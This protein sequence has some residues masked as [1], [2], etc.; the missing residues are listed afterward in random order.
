MS[1]TR[2]RILKNTTPKSLTKKQL[3]DRVK[4]LERQL[5][6]ARL[7][8]AAYRSMIEIAEEEFKIQ[9]KKKWGTKPSK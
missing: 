5:E 2:E 9:I 8:E 4:K 6:E 3:E 7:K 1:E